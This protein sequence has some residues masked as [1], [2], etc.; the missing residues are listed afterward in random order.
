MRV[1]YQNT[2]EFHSGWE[3]CGN[4]HHSVDACLAAAE[5]ER[6]AHSV[7]KRVIPAFD[8]DEGFWLLNNCS[9]S[10]ISGPALRVDKDVAG[11][12]IYECVFDGR[13]ISYAKIICGEVSTFSFATAN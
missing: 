5:S 6:P 7:F 8:A 3:S 10:D 1:S 11:L 2:F 4:K 13:K 12:E 9:F